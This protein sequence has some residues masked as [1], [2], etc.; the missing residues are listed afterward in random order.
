M[1]ALLPFATR[2]IKVS[3]V[4]K[5][6]AAIYGFGRILGSMIS[7]ILLPFYTHAL[8]SAG[9]YG[10]VQIIVAFIAFSNIVFLF[11]FDSALMKYYVSSKKVVEKQAY[12]TN[13]YLWVFGFGLVLLFLMFAFRNIFSSYVIADYDSSLIVKIA[14]ILFLDALRAIH[15]LV[16][17]AENRAFLFTITLLL[18]II[19]LACFNV[20]FVGLKGFGVMGVVYA[21]FFSSCILFALTLPIIINR[22]TY[23]SISFQ[24]WNK[25]RLF[26]FPLM[27]AGL[28]WMILEFADRKMLEFLI[29]DN[30][31]HVVGIYGAGYKIGSLMLLLVYAFNYAWRPYF[32]KKNN[33]LAFQKISSFFFFGLGF[34]YVLLVL[35]VEGLVTYKLPIINTSFIDD[36]FWDG[37]VIVPFIA[38]A[39]I[40]H[41]SFILQ[42]AGPFLSNSVYK[43]SV[44]RAL[45]VIVN[46]FLNFILIP[47]FEKPY[48]AAAIATLIAY[49]VMSAALYIWNFKESRF[50]YDNIMIIIIFLNICFVWFLSFYDFTAIK[51]LFPLLYLIQFKYYIRFRFPS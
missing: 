34:F 41:G 39:Y 5:K 1:A 19:L 28:F 45:G 29:I 46:V 26:A 13:T 4:L 7:F 27:P 2:I 11:G 51:V 9:E 48:L 16:L 10:V 32:L 12:L 33:L 50:R 6:E 42:E 37:L 15:M 14:V 3:S 31:L 20:Y 40:F 43:I 25:L 47:N 35:Y 36:K 30:S 18:D 17:R 44:C 23:S 21:N 49:F 8:N 38:L 22:F 24:V